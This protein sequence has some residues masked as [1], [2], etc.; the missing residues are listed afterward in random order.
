MRFLVKVKQPVSTDHASEQDTLFEERL[1]TLFQRL[2]VQWNHTALEEGRRIYWF[3]VEIENLPEIHAVA[4]RIFD[5][6]RLKAEFLPE[7]KP[8]SYFGQPTGPFPR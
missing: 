5:T 3:V 1:R 8:K 4:A 2:K 7:V 6:L